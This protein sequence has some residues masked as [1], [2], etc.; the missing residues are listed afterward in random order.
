MRGCVRPCVGGSV[1]ESVSIKEKRDISRTRRILCRVSGL[2]LLLILLIDFGITTQ[3]L[4]I[5]R[6]ADVVGNQKY[7][8]R[9]F[10]SRGKK[11]PSGEQHFSG[12]N[13]PVVYKL[14]L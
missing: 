13:G 7:Y 10:R 1:R 3:F 4:E 6:G 5:F 2:V 8:N 11:I 12:V 14:M 9:L